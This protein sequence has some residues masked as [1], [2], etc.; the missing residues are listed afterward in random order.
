MMLDDIVTIVKH[1]GKTVEQDNFISGMYDTGSDIQY[2]DFLI[3][4][5]TESGC[6]MIGYVVQIRKQLGEFGSNMFLIR[7]ADGDLVR[8]ENQSFWKLT[9]EQTKK[10]KPFFF[11]NLPE[12]ELKLNPDIKYLLEGSQEMSGFIIH[13]DTAPS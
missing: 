13:K 8:H 2:G 3:S 10:I 12:N 1:I 7:H 9:D 11:D 5:L 4:G 6:Q